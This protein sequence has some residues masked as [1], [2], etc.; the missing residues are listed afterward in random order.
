MLAAQITW[1]KNLLTYFLWSTGTHLAA[2]C[3]LVTSTDALMQTSP[4]MQ[5]VI[6]IHYQC[7][8]SVLLIDGCTLIDTHSAT[9][10]A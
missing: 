7:S 2:E 5:K 9:D 3:L 1:N 6:E 10:K 4:G 8:I